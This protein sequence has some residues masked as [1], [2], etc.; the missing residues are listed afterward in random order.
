MFNV[1]FLKAE[2]V[3][4][5]FVHNHHQFFD[6][7]RS[8]EDIL[9]RRNVPCLSEFLNDDFLGPG[10]SIITLQNV[11]SASIGATFIF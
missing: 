1:V 4:L 2:R 6:E 10:A 8:K 3:F 9:Y 5:M 11:S 7:R